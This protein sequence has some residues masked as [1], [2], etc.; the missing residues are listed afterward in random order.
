MLTLENKTKAL[1]YIQNHI[2]LITSADI[3]NDIEN[4]CLKIKNEIL[5]ALSFFQEDNNSLEILNRSQDFYL[6]NLILKLQTKYKDFICNLVLPELLSPCEIN[7][8]FKV[9]KPSN[10]VNNDKVETFVRYI[11]KMGNEK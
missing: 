7:R 2:E 10:N 11:Y 5:N 6:L 8:L 1:D 4:E 3:N 9:I